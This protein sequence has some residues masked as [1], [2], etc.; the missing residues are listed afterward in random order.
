MKPDLSQAE[1]EALLG[2]EVR[3]NDVVATRDFSRPMRI[4]AAQL[5]DLKKKI[6]SCLPAIERAMTPRF[7]GDLALTLTHIGETTRSSFVDT[8]EERDFFVQSF[9]L[10]GQAGWVYWAPNDARQAIEKSLG[11]GSS[12][13]LDAPLSHLERA[14]AGGFTTEIAARLSS[15]LGTTLSDGECFIE[16]RILQASLDAAPADD[17]QRLSV[18]L[19]LSSDT[20]SSELRFY[21]P[22]VTPDDAQPAPVES[23][24]AL[25]EHLNEIGVTLSAEIASLEL[26]LQDVLDLEE[27][28]VLALGPKSEM[29]AQLTLNGRPAGTATYGRDGE[30]LALLVEELRVNPNN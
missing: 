9:A 29:R 21:L 27:G 17:E 14:L 13:A 5:D 25:P 20:L 2:E 1:V 22:G 30:R 7:R 16:K 11:C 3:S 28:D 8:L 12:A 15:Q 24:K 10:N 18:T 19:Q 4:G 23:P 6:N 26:P